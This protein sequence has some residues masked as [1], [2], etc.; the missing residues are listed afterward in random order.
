[1]TAGVQTVHSVHASVHPPSRNCQDCEDCQDRAV[2]AGR[3][4]LVPSWMFLRVHLPFLCASVDIPPCCYSGPVLV[5]AVLALFV[6]RLVLGVCGLLPLLLH[7]C[8]RPLGTACAGTVPTALYPYLQPWRAGCPR[9]I[10]ECGHPRTRSDSGPPSPSHLRPYPYP[11]HRPSLSLSSLL[12]PLTHKH[13]HIPP[14]TALPT[15]LETPNVLPT[16]LSPLSPLIPS[17]HRPS[18][19]G[20]CFDDTSAHTDILRSPRLLCFAPP[21]YQQFGKAFIC[22]PSCPSFT[23]T[24]IQVTATSPPAAS[25]LLLLSGSVVILYLFSH[26]FIGICAERSFLDNCCYFST[27][28][29]VHQT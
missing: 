26:C 8:T 24:P 13:T 23:R 22:A 20:T 5:L 4:R 2:P 12:S 16:V 3:C 17:S 28:I 25:L 11:Y 15:R 19:R 14:T 21:I 27:K 6:L 1:M 18:P 29:P 10:E 9:R 7:L